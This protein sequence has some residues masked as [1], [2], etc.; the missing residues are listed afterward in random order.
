MSDEI[1]VDRKEAAR[2]LS[3]SP[4][5]VD[6]LRRRGDLGCRR[7][8]RKVLFPVQELERFANTLPADEPRSA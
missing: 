4:S 6:V 5:E 8:G 3:L 2:R 1:F 7:Y